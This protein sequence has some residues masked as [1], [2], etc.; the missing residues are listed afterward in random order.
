MKKFA[1]F[2][3]VLA[4]VFFASQS[5]AQVD[6]KKQGTMT[7]SDKAAQPKKIY[8]AEGN[9]TYTVDQL[10]WIRNPKNRAMGQYTS[11]GEYISKRVVLGRMENGV[12]YDRYGKEFARI[13]QDGRVTDAKGTALGTIKADGTI[14]NDK[15]TKIGSA[16]GVD[17]NVAAIIF[18][19]QNSVQKTKTKTS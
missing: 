18:F 5:V 13:G 10:G 3:V 15:G 4:G 9:L 6:S 12:F 17:K 16:P 1:L 11:K 8:D 2:I 19:L 14:L 7:S